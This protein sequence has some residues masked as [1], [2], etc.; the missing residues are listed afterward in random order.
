[1]T[2]NEIMPRFLN[3]EKIRR[4]AWVSDLYLQIRDGIQARLFSD[5]EKQLL[6]V[7]EPFTLEDIISTDWEFFNVNQ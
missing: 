7:D 1:M 4:K 2:L 3:G 5:N 6:S